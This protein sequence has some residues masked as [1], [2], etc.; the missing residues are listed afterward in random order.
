MRTAKAMRT[1]V[2]K[3]RY[4]KA[5]G[6]QAV[7]RDAAR[8]TAVAAAATAIGRV[9]ARAEGPLVEGAGLTVG[10]RPVAA[11][12]ITDGGAVRDLRL[13]EDLTLVEGCD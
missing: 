11:V 4:Q 1:K 9:T 10:L 13:K 7:M 3:R 2:R 8:F 12:S 6:Q 5:G